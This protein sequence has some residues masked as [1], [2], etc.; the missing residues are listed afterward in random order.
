M[1]H[2]ERFSVTDENGIARIF[3]MHSI[4]Q[5]ERFQPVPFG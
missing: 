5:M 1:T 2:I 4:G 3:P